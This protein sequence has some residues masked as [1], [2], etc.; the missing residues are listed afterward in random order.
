MK[1]TKDLKLFIKQIKNHYSKKYEQI[2]AYLLSN[3]SE[4]EEHKSN[5]ELLLNNERYY[6]DEIEAI[7]VDLDLQQAEEE[8]NAKVHAYATEDYIMEYI[9]EQIVL[10]EEQLMRVRSGNVSTKKAIIQ[11]QNKISKIITRLEHLN[12]IK[13]KMQEIEPQEKRKVGRPKKKKT[14]TPEQVVLDGQVGIEEVGGGNE[15]EAN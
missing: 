5:I 13:C 15:K 3:E 12:K 4:I 2:V 8:Y 10:N 6:Y 7:K 14:I 1:I 11:K 9:E